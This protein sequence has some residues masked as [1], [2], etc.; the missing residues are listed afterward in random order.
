MRNHIL[1]TGVDLIGTGVADG[2]DGPHIVH[3]VHHLLEKLRKE[4]LSLSNLTD[5]V[6]WLH[7]VHSPHHLLLLLLHHCL[8]IL[9]A[10]LALGD[11]RREGVARLPD[12]LKSTPLRNVA[13]PVH[14]GR[15]LILYL[16][17]VRKE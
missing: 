10:H 4:S 17:E 14:V 6:P 12:G 3:G 9:G 15:E 2:S 13:W 16:H 8:L 11:V 1:V 7:V 5:R